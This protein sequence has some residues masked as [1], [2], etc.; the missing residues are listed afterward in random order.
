MISE[1][2]IHNKVLFSHHS[3]FHLVIVDSSP[4]ILTS[5]Q[6]NVVDLL[7]I[8]NAP[9]FA[10][11]NLVVIIVATQ[12]PLKL[13][14]ITYFSWKKQ[15]DTLLIGYDLYDFIDGSLPCPLP[16]L[17]DKNLNSNYLFWIH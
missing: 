6:F 2:I 17:P 12:A 9:I 14:K 7:T 4:N 11:L 10:N 3:Y 15:F 16:T 5:K 1:Q 8:N 13:T